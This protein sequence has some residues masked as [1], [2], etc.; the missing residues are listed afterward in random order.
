MV[1][2]PSSNTA[3]HLVEGSIPSLPQEQTDILLEGLTMLLG[4]QTA[5]IE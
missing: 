5:T 2:L 3:S 4:T 1:W